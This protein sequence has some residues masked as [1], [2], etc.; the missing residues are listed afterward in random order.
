ME[1]QKK[2]AR[3]ENHGGKRTKPITHICCHFTGNLGDTAK[4]NI[5][6]FAREVTGTSAHLFVDEI[7]VW[8][9]VEFDTIAYHCGAKKYYH[10]T[11][12]NANSIGVEICMLDKNGRIR[13]KS[14]DKA[15][16]VV[17]MLMNRYGIDREHVVRHWDVSRKSCPEPMIGE[18]NAMWNEFLDRLEDDDMTQEKFNEMMEVYL[19]SRNTNK[20]AGWSQEARQFLTDN[21]L[22]AGNGTEIDGEPNYCWPKLMSR[23]EFATVIYRVL[24]FIGK[25]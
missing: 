9:S 14:I 13:Q 6:F 7:E 21:G 17:R 4:N 23:E 19:A 5:D 18:N 3:K 20:A 11:C 12:R 16:E 15:V 10:P 2:L 22:I 25:A 8:Q 1:I 24:K